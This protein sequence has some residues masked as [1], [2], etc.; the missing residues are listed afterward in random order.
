VAGGGRSDGEGAFGGDLVVPNPTDRAKNG[1]KRSILVEANGGGPL[2]VV[3]AGANV[4]DY[5]KLLEATL[6]AIVV[7]RPAPTEKAPQHLCLDKGYDDNEPRAGKSYESEVTSLTSGAL[8]RRRNARLARSGIRL[9]GGS[10]N[11]P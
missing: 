5:F 6:E 2:S 8:A 9:V 3:I 10:S 1:V 11:A 7:E 4:P